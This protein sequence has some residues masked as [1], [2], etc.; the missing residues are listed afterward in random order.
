MLPGGM[1]HLH[2]SSPAFYFLSEEKIKI[3]LAVNQPCG[4]HLIGSGQL[5]QDLADMCM[6]G[7][8]PSSCQAENTQA[9]HLSPCKKVETSLQ[10]LQKCSRAWTQLAGLVLLWVL[11]TEEGHWDRKL[12]SRTNVLSHVSVPGWF[13]PPRQHRIHEIGSF[14][15]VCRVTSK[16]KSQV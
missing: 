3:C 9:N 8:V 4:S 2:P 13:V 5:G 11:G 14:F 12:L 6:P 10:L 15:A 7:Q 16:S 1:A